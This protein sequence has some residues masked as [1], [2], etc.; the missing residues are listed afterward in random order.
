MKIVSFDNPDN[1]SSWSPH[2]VD[3]FYVGPALQHHRCYTVYIPSTGATRI[4]DQL[5][6]HP[7]PSTLFLTTLP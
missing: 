3:G 2:G 5:S 7:H 1:R 4:T 6:W